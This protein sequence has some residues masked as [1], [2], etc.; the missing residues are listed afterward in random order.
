[1]SDPSVVV[2]AERSGRAGAGPAA[3]G[4][5][6][7]ADRIDALSDRV[8]P[9]VVK[10]VRQ[11]VRGRDFMAAFACGLA[12]GIVISFVA[13]I[14]AMG[15]SL[16]AGR[17]AF[18]TL[19][20]CLA[21]LGLAVV[22]I[23]AF[24]ALRTERL[25]QTLDL[26]S[27][28]TMSPRRIIVGK[29]MAQILK[30]ITF[31]SAM[32][33]F[34]ATS[35]LLGGVDLP[36]ILSGLGI[37]FLWS[38]WVAAA[39]MLISTAFKSRIMSTL[40]LGVFALGVFFVYSVGQALMLTMSSGA[41]ASI[42]IGGIPY[43]GARVSVWW[44]FATVI[45]FC[46]TTLM[47]LVLLAESR[48]ALPT[49]DRVPVLRVGFLIQFLMLIAWL[50]ILNESGSLTTGDVTGGLLFLGSAHL[51]LVA[52]FG[53][54]EGLT[55]TSVAAALP[56]P[57]KRWPRLLA[58]LGAGTASAVVYVVLQ[59]V[60]FVAAGAYL[61]DWDPADT[62]L[63]I[64]ICGTILLFTAVPAL[65]VHYARRVPMG[66]FH[67]RGLALVLLAATMLL[68]DTLYYLLWSADETFS[69]AFAKRHLFSPARIPFNWEWIERNDWQIAPLLWG[70]LGS[71]CCVALLLARSAGS[72]RSRTVTNLGLV[73]GASGDGDSN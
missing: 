36:T 44:P 69:A 59:M 62:R 3:R 73:A 61:T 65:I 63:L 39:A 22:P 18:T 49:E 35:F 42:Y 5:A 55:V 28:T 68:P 7:W 26:I 25:E 37:L 32:A 15:G 53:L 60:L 72:R 57:L 8:S 27:L 58:V 71:I 10:E 41:M 24:A 9:L 29:L 1:M 14:E 19:M 38:V 45:L 23:G 67:A 47:N 66:P 4:P 17:T 11:F 40:A 56:G 51:V 21:L 43:S 13:S 50:L 70:G 48:L 54:T 20:I 2:E 34:V 12:I 46:L 64:A 30:L 6:C 31:F 33:P 52:L 16:T